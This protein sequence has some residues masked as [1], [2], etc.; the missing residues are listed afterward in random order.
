[1]TLR[2]KE[3]IR[4]DI[5]NADLQAS[6]LAMQGE[7]TMLK[8][9]LAQYRA[10]EEFQRL[11]KQQRL[12]VAQKEAFELELREVLREENPAPPST[13]RSGEPLRAVTPVD[14][15]AA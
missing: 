15:E 7:N 4:R 6:V 8:A 5:L 14:A 13:P 2:D 3:I 9:E 11:A 10:P 12:V 1:M